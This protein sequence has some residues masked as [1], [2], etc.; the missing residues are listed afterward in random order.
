MKYNC[1]QF[2]ENLEVRITQRIHVVEKRA[3]VRRV[4][5][6]GSLSIVSFAG[7]VIMGV[8][9]GKTMSQSGV[10]QYASVVV[11]DS[12]AIG[13]YW[14]ELVLSIVESLPILGVTIFL[15]AVGLFMWSV[16]RVLQNS[17]GRIGKIT[18]VQFN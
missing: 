1:V 7:I 14:K 4:I 12:S 6:L 13:S 15:I 10:S 17:R 2:P 16:A 5:G 8:F 9:I 3:K 18:S 11:S